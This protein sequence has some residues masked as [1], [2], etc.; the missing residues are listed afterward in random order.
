MLSFVT[1]RKPR[2]PAVLLAQFRYPHDPFTVETARAGEIFEHTLLLI[3]EHVKQGL[4]VDLEGRGQLLE[5]FRSQPP[6]RSETDR[7]SAFLLQNTM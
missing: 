4:T 3:Q 2:T 7:A 1:C 6:V 5:A